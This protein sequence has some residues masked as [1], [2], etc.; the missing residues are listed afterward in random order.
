[1]FDRPELSGLIGANT[2]DQ[3]SGATLRE[4]FYWLDHYGIEYVVDRIPPREWGITRRVFKTYRNILSCRIVPGIITTIF[5][6][7]MGDANPIRGIEFS[8]Y[9]MD[10]TRDTPNDTFKVI[11]SRLRESPDYRRGLITTTTNGEDWAY[12]NFVTKTDKLRGSM[13]IPTSS[14][15]RC[16]VISQEF[17]DMLR[18][19]YDPLFAAQELDAEHVDVLGGRAYYGFGKWNTVACPWGD[20]EPNPSRPLIVG[21][22]FNYDPAPMLWMIGQLGPDNTPYADC[23][24][25]FGEVVGRQLSTRQQAQLML[26]TYGTGFF[27]QCFGDAS[28]GRGSTSNA[29]EHDFAQLAEE[30]D[31]AGVG[32]TIDFDPANPRVIDRVTNMN[33]L[34]KNSL[35]QVAMTYDKQACPYFHE[36]VRKVGWRKTIMGRGRLD[37]KGN[38]NLTHASDGAGYAA[39]KLLP[40]ARRGEYTEPI[41]TSGGLSEIRSIG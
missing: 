32:R 20:T 36:D 16:G 25:W 33:R 9:W 18:A 1:M 31:I 30:L 29:G 38:H 11:L 7:V 14:S 5:T 23:I 8:W 13:H 41:P 34:A 10:E 3:L 6:R 15:V 4:L 40:M 26:Q 17:Y 21:M 39:W 12:E 24:H 35:G 19:S 22:D 2:Y 28:G 37:D 27:Y